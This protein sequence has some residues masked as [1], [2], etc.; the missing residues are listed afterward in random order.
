VNN[1]IPRKKKAVKIDPNIKFATI[2]EVWE[3]QRE[4][5]DVE[6]DTDESS[7]S[8]TPSVAEEC[9]VVASRDY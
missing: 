7:A 1:S 3:A 8:D 6:S 2:R 5:G 4:A 9:I